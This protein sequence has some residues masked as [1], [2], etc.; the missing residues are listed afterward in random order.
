MKVKPAHLLDVLVSGVLL[1]SLLGPCARADSMLTKFA[2]FMH[3]GPAK[4]FAVTDEVPTKTEVELAGCANAWCQIR[5][6]AAYGWVE[7][8]MLA[9]TT[10]TARPQPGARPA[11][12]FDFVRTGWPDAGNLYGLCI[13]PPGGGT[14]PPETNKPGG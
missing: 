7:K 10:P 3:A 5:Y 14:L 11:E 6:G 1:T 13:Y 12:C 4:A 8:K 2:T 9:A